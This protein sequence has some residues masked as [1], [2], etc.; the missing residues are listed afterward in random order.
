MKEKLSRGSLFHECKVVPGVLFIG[1]FIPGT[2]FIIPSAR[3]KGGRICNKPIWIYLSFVFRQLRGK[4]N[5][6]KTPATQQSKKFVFAFEFDSSN[7]EHYNKYSFLACKRGW[8]TFI[9]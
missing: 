7:P 8:L 3:L 6:R 9:H 1:P 2:L 4:T 5:C